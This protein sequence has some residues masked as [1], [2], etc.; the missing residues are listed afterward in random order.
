[1][2]QFLVNL[3][4]NHQT[5]NL[6]HRST[7]FMHAS[8]VESICR[9]KAIPA[10]H[11]CVSCVGRASSDS[12]LVVAPPASHVS[13]LWLFTCLSRCMKRQ[14]CLHGPL[15]WNGNTKTNYQFCTAAPACGQAPLPWIFTS[16]IILSSKC[17]KHC[18]ILYRWTGRKFSHLFISTL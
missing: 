7:Y 16:L 18:F 2:L 12:G 8:G 17:S 4:W 3:A 14:F 11:S 13:F 10:N 15:K 1:M 9:T 6:L 5:H